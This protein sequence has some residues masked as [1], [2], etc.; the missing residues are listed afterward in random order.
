MKIISIFLKNLLT[1]SRNWSYFLVLFI[2]PLVLILI[3][4]AMLQSNNLANIKIGVVNEDPGFYIGIGERQYSDTPQT[5]DYE[6]YERNIIN[7]ANLADCI[8]DLTNSKNSLCINVIGKDGPH[9]ITVYLDNTRRLMSFYARQFVLQKVLD[10]QT[11]A[12]EQTS[13][14][15]NQKFLVITRFEFSKNELDDLL[16]FVFGFSL[17]NPFSYFRKKIIRIV[18]VHKKTSSKVLISLLC[19]PIS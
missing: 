16:K 10:T 2:C 9:Q 18:K 5:F 13:D 11:G 17:F 1:I 15:F 7:Y 8:F 4:G 14:T 6:E 19:I 12:I 3:S